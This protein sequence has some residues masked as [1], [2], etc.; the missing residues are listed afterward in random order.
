MEARTKKKSWI[1][2]GIIISLA[3]IFPEVSI[4]TIGIITELIEKSNNEKMEQKNQ[5]RDFEAARE[6]ANKL[7]LD[8]EQKEQT[9][10]RISKA[11]LNVMVVNNSLE[12][13]ENLAKELNA[14]PEFFCSNHQQ[15]RQIDLR[16]MKV[17][18]LFITN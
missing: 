1:T 17:M 9:L 16:K 15:S 14:M 5:E 18:L 6:L 10:S 12:D 3:V 8:T 7:D 2:C 13:T 4:I 11:Q